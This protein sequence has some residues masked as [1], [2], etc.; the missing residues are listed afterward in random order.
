MSQETVVPSARDVEMVK[1]WSEQRC[2]AAGGPRFAGEEESECDCNAALAAMFARARK[3]ERERVA[4]QAVTVFFG[5]KS[6]REDELIRRIRALKET[7]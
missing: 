2:K 5:G 7:P 4:E 1:E 3:E 6:A